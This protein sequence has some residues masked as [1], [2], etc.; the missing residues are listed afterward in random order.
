MSIGPT[1]KTE[2]YAGTFVEDQVLGNLDLS[3]EFEV[4]LAGP[5][6]VLSEP[7]S[8]GRVLGSE[9]ERPDPHPPWSFALSAP[10][11]YA[12]SRT[13]SVS[14]WNVVGNISN[15]SSEIALYPNVAKRRM[16]RVSVAGSQET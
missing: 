16:S 7:S 6:N 5:P 4:G 3:R 10:A 14:M 1:S 15:A 2:F 13:D 8:A 12:L 11:G 9:R